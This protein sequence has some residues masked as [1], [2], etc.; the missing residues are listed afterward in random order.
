MEESVIK[1]TNT[2]SAT[3]IEQ[4]HRKT[5]NQE[6]SNAKT[7]P[8]AKNQGPSRLWGVP[9]EGPPTGFNNSATRGLKTPFRGPRGKRKY[10]NCVSSSSMHHQNSGLIGLRRVQTTD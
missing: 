8:N 1:A 7:H 6:T 2:K 9:T 3:R 4:A 5:S 10:G